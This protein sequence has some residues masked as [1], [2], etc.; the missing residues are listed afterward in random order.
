MYLVT[1]WTERDGSVIYN[2]EVIAT[3]SWGGHLALVRAWACENQVYLMSST[4]SPPEPDEIVFGIWDHH[5]D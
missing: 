2:A 1:G 3:P 4:Y 5:E